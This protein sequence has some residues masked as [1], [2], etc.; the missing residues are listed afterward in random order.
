MI[1][2]VAACF[3][4]LHYLSAIITH[5][6]LPCISFFSFQSCALSSVLA[7]AFIGLALF[8]NPILVC[9]GS[10]WWYRKSNYF[11][12]NSKEIVGINHFEEQSYYPLVVFSLESEAFRFLRLP[13]IDWIKPSQSQYPCQ[14][15]FS[16]QSD[17]ISGSIPFLGTMLWEFSRN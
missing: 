4:S 16:L 13:R 1:I 11:H 12:Q 17:R 14:M 2:A 5:Y 9:G 7:S 15:A 6:E 10:C 3:L 8:L